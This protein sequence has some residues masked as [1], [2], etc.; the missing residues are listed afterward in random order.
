MILFCIK[1]MITFNKKEDLSYG[2]C[3]T[4]A[5]VIEELENLK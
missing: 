5:D 4:S 3:T 2:Y 1:E